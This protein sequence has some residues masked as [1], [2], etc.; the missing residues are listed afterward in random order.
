MATPVVV[1]ATAKAALSK[2]LRRRIGCGC[3]LAVT[4]PV[5]CVFLVL[6]GVLGGAQMVLGGFDEAEG[7]ATAAPA[8]GGGYPGGEVSYD[9]DGSIF[10]DRGGS[11]NAWGGHSNGR[12]PDGA[13]CSLSMRP[14]LR[15]RCDAADALDRLNAAYVAEFGVSIAV[16]DAYRDHAGQVAIKKSWCDRG[17][18]AMAATPG[19]SNHGWAIAFDLGGGINTYGSAPYAWMKNNAAAFGFYHPTWAEPGHPDYAKPEP[20]HWQYLS[21]ADPSA[22]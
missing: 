16:T 5:L 20:W 7:L 6:V 21:G 11:A 13:L 19:T 9:A 12:I 2:K 3:L 18:C 15:A 1:A 22:R 4:V 8:A 10:V 14:A 17:R